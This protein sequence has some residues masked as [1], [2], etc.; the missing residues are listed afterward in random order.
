MSGQWPQGPEGPD[1]DGPGPVEDFFAA[2]RAQVREEPAD[3]LTWQR[4]RDGRRR[5]SPRRSGAWAGGL[6]AAAAALAVVFGPSLIPD[7]DVPDAAGPATST[8]PSATEPAATDPSTTDPSTM[9]PSTTDPSTTDPTQT[10]PTGTDSST[11]SVTTPIPEGEIPV[12]SWFTDITSADP[13]PLT[14]SGVRFGIV[15]GTCPTTGHC[16]MLVTSGD[17]GLLWL[18]AADLSALGPVDR[19]QFVDNTRGWVWG[20]EAGVWATTNGGGT[21]T[22]VSFAGDRVLDL[23]VRD[24]TLVALS[25]SDVACVSAPCESSLLGAVTDPLASNW[26]DGANALGSA[27][28]AAVQEAGSATYVMATSASDV[29]EGLRLQEGQLET[30][31][32]LT[33]CG[34]GPVGI[35]GSQQDPDHLWAL[36]NDEAGL[37]LQESDNGG[38]TWLPSNLTVPSF[39]LGERP[40]LM[41]STAADQLLLIGAGNYAVTT[42]GGASWS[43]E[44]F[45][46]GA[47]SAP[48]SLELTQLGDV[49]VYP[50]PEQAGADLGYWQS[51]DGGATWEVMTAHP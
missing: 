27:Q 50:T 15:E 42:D 13:E 33:A 12:G 44:A 31:A 51:V 36:C 16:S 29:V 8:G 10:E 22:P 20:A 3:E 38:R 17:G 30:M 49:I 43:E 7:A 19:V 5:E 4:I 35:T 46:P 39:V 28:D 6:V 34:A 48:D 11:N 37:A 9:D 18:P 26:I 25:A 45:L 2:H 32:G 24:D 1:R 47:T 23:S 41:S 21:W 40:P 14:D